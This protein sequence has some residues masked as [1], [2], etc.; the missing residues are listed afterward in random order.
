L[1]S[2]GGVTKDV[3]PLLRLASM[4]FLS[5]AVKLLRL[6][7]AI[8]AVKL[9][10]GLLSKLH[11]SPL[12]PGSM[13]HD[14]PDLIRVLSELPAPTTYEAYLRTLRAVVDWRGQVVTMLDR[15]YLTENL[16]VLLVWGEQDSVIPVAHAR[17]AHSAMPGSKLEVFD[18][19]GHFPFRD[20]PMRF[21]Q[22]LEDFIDSTPSL[23]FDE[24]RWRN[25]LITGV[26]EDMISGSS[27]T[28]MAVLG[29]MGSDERSA[30]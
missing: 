7:G 14:T 28:R 30:T 6:P 8:P 19:S 12:R 15:C 1:V 18:N 20:D 22:V 5:E 21:L 9:V 11:S 17:L 23:S 13:L 3:H 29:A 2:S 4:P 10:G 24:V 25:L 27:S 16:P 26:G